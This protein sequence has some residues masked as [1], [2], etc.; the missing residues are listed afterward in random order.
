LQVLT[1]IAFSCLVFIQSEKYQMP[2]RE[3]CSFC[4]WHET[5]RTE[6]YPI[7]WY[8]WS[9][10]SVWLS[11]HRRW[12]YCQINL[13]IAFYMKLSRNRGNEDK[14]IEVR[15][16]LLLIVVRVST[17]QDTHSVCV[18]LSNLFVTKRLHSLASFNCKREKQPNAKNI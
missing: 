7:S 9:M 16:S 17:Q 13:S 11:C 6:N 18:C 2:V 5:K 4:A 3:K 12:P 8:W 1:L 14:N 10:W 15:T